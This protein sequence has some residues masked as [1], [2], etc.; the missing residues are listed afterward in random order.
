M[1]RV[2]SRSYWQVTARVNTSAVWADASSPSSC[3]V[4]WICP[5]E[6]GLTKPAHDRDDALLVGVLD[7][8][9]PG[10]GVAVGAAVVGLGDGADGAD[11]QPGHG[12]GLDR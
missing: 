2:P 3:L 7:R 6:N 12:F 5:A 4:T 11:R 1:T 9:G 8:H 10:G